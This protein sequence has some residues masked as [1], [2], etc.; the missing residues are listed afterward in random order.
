MAHD[1][2]IRGGLLVDGTGWEPVRGDLAIADGVITAVGEVESSSR[3]ALDRYLPAPLP[4]EQRQGTL[5]VPHVQP[6]PRRAA[7]SA[8]EPA[9]II[10]L[11]D[12]GILA[13][14]MRADVNVFDPEPVSERPPEIAPDFPGGAPRFL[15]RSRGYR[16][17]IVN[18]Q[19][20]VLEGEHTGARARTVLRHP[21]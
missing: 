6:E 4:R 10:G 17:T 3:R 18:G 11:S 14:G 1:I 20:S 15:S 16:A 2:V 12:R 9:R 7:R 8:C 21:R 13:P 5:H 19:V